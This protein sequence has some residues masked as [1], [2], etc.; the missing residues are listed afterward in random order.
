MSEGTTEDGKASTAG[1]GD[2]NV[3]CSDD[4]KYE[5]KSKWA[6]VGVSLFHLKMYRTQALDFLITAFLLS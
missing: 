3:D 4:E 2:W 1:N 6:T 5:I